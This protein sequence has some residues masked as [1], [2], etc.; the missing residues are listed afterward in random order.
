VKILIVALALFFAV[1]ASAQECVTVK[2]AIE[3]MA[4]DGKRVAKS[5]SGAEAVALAKKL[6]APY[7]PSHLV[8]YVVGDAVII[9]SF[10]GGCYAETVGGNLASFNKVAPGVL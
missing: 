7:E 1:P 8:I 9:L 4:K 10:K 5:L 6:G 3:L 2:A